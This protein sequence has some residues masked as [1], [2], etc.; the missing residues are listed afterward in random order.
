[1]V[2]KSKTLP[3]LRSMPVLAYDHLGKQAGSAAALTRISHWFKHPHQPSQLQ[4]PAG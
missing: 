1:M 2:E 3:K 4:Q